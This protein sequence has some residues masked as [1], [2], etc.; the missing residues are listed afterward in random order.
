MRGLRPMLLPGL[1]L[2]LLSGCNMS[3]KPASDSQLPPPAPMA[4]PVQ[5]P[6]MPA[7]YVVEPGD[8]VYGLARRFGIDRHELIRTNN[9]APPYKLLVGQRL[10]LPTPAGA[11]TQSAMA[12]PSSPPPAVGSVVPPMPAEQVPASEAGAG[13]PPPPGHSGVT[14]VPLPPPPGMAAK[15]AAPAAPPAV[16]PPP[17]PPPAAPAPAP[18][19]GAPL[20]LGKAPPPAATASAAAPPA[21]VESAAVP[22][23]PAAADA[24]P[25]AGAGKFL[26]PVNGKVI[27]RYGSIANGLH[28]DGINIAVP[29][30]TP[31][32]AADSGVVAYAGNELKGFGNLL[33]IRHPNGWMSAYAHNETLLVK[34][35]DTVKRGQVIAKSGATGN[36]TS[37]QLHF[38]LRHNTEAVDPQSYLGSS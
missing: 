20:P 9:L 34:R 5:A 8:S 29:P 33:L 30:G 26:W 25:A 23:K 19:A 21:P 7:T 14:A 38:E 27:A 13:V 31:V 6:A 28:N 35:G 16:V 24:K 17:S 1:A 22:A 15:P 2:A 37:P 10:T 3:G 18:S 36:V 12:V 4:A 11:V 32:I